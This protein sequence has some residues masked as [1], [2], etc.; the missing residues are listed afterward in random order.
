MTNKSLG[1]SRDQLAAFLKDP[2]S[3]KQF[4]NLFRVV[5][6]VAPHVDAVISGALESSDSKADIALSLLDRLATAL[7][8]LALAPNRIKN[9]KSDDALTPAYVAP[10]LPPEIGIDPPSRYDELWSLI[11]ALP[12]LRTQTETPGASGFSVT[13][14]PLY[15]GK[16]YDIW[17]L[18][19]PAAGYAAGTIVLPASSDCIDQQ[20][21]TVS[22]TQQVNALTVDGNGATVTG[23]P[24][25]LAADSTFKLRYNLASTTWHRAE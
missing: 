16:I 8:L 22:C 13:I 9:T 14:S 3:I 18:L 5:D 6:I 11:Q 17:L 23:E 2:Q 25:A 21:V 24:S 7:E 20:E 12:A 4:E 1:L 10:V 15:N 19:K